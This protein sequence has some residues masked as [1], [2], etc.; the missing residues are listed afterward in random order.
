MQD[1]SP[2]VGGIFFLSITFPTD[3]P[4]NPPE[5]RFTTKIYNPNINESGSFYMVILRDRW[6]PQLTLSLGALCLYDTAHSRSSSSP[7]VL[8]SICS[9]LIDPDLDDSIMP[10]IAHLYRTDR[11]RYEATAKQWTRKWVSALL[12]PELLY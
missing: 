3:Y 12:L 2:Y 1:N 11:P 6:G 7:L 4:F 5:V 10:E 8:R 9:I